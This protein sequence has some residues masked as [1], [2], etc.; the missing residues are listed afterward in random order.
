M[1]IA[2]TIKGFGVSFMEDAAAWHHKV[3]NAEEYQK[4]TAELA[5]RRSAAL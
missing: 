2:D 5:E 4:A 1:I 3:P